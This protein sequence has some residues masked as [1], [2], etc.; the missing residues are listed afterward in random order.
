MDKNQK[1]I[2]E[3]RTVLNSIEAMQAHKRDVD[4]SMAKC[5]RK[6]LMYIRTS[7]DNKEVLIKAEVAKLQTLRKVAL[8]ADN[9]VSKLATSMSMELFMKS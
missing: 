8:I 7:A 4:S 1:V 3:V 6:I 2:A 9:K 5:E